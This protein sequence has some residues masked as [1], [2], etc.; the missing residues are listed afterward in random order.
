M[1]LTI[2]TLVTT[3]RSDGQ[4]R[5]VVQSVGHP[6]FTATDPL[7]KVALQRLAN[8]TRK[9]LQAQVNKGFA[10]AIAGWLFDSQATVQ[11]FKDQLSLRDR[12]V[13][14]KTIL[15]TNKTPG[16]FVVTAPLLN[17][18]R[19][20]RNERSQFHAQAVEMLTKW[21]EH[22]HKEEPDLDLSQF[23][24]TGDVWL[25]PLDILLT[26]S[27][28]KKKKKTGMM[29][30][31]LGQANPGG[32]EA[33]QRVGRCLDSFR[34]D[35]CKLFGRDSEALRLNQL[36]QSRRNQ[37]VLLVGPASVGKTAILEEVVRQRTQLRPN[38]L[39]HLEQ[40]WLIT[41][42]RVISGMSY[43]GQWEER[44]LSI[45][46][47]AY[48]KNH[49]L[50]FDD[51]IGLYTAGI[52]R[53]SQ[54]CLADVLKAFMAEHPIRIVFETTHEGLSIL[55]RRD[56]SL[57]DPMSPMVIEP[58]SET[59]TIRSLIEVVSQIES[60]TKAFFHPGL[61]PRMVEYSSILAPQQSMPGKVISLARG[62]AQQATV[63][64]GLM[65]L[66]SQAVNSDPD[67]LDDTPKSKSLSGNELDHFIEER[68]GL[69]LALRNGTKSI[70]DLRQELERMIVGQQDAVDVLSRYAQRSLQGL[71]P[72]DKPLGVFLFMG[73]TGV[74]KTE[75]A[76][77][78][79]R[80]LFLDDTRIV[81]I[82]MNEITSASAAEGLIGTLDQPDGRLSAA[83]RRQPNCVLLL[84]EIEKAHPD[85]LD[86]LLQVMGEGRLSDA[87]GRSVDFRNAF[88]IMTSNLGSVE[89]NQSLG[90]ETQDPASRSQQQASVYHRAAKRYFRP[91][92]LNRLDEIVVFGRL[93]R[94][95]MNH[96]VD[97]HLGS[98]KSRDGLSRRRI[99]LQVDQD[100]IEWIIDRGYDASLGARA[101]KRAIER[102]VA[103]PLA[104]RL[105][106]VRID[107]P[108]WTQLRV[109]NQSIQ[110]DT[111]ELSLLP[112]GKQIVEPML[113]ES[114]AQGKIQLEKIRADL[115]AR[116]PS[117][118]EPSKPLSQVTY[119]A[120]HGAWTE[121]NDLWKETKERLEADKEYSIAPISTI[122]SK[123][124]KV[125]A[126]SKS[127]MGPN[128]RLRD[129]QI[130]ELE[131]KEAI[132]GT[133]ADGN[134]STEATPARRL[135][136]SIAMAKMMLDCI[137][138][139]SRWLL[140]CRFLNPPGVHTRL[141]F[142]R[143][144]RG[145]ILLSLSMFPEQL[146]NW[147]SKLLNDFQYSVSSQEVF[148]YLIVDG[149]GV[150]GLVECLLG[151][152]QVAND[153]GME[154]LIVIE[155][156]PIDESIT[157]DN[158][159]ACQE[160][161]EGFVDSTNGRPSNGVCGRDGWT[162]IRGQLDNQLT[163]FRS[164]GSVALTYNKTWPGWLLDQLLVDN[165]V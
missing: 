136:R 92:F 38:K 78:L 57:V 118:P 141:N 10:N 73:P 165:S 126:H 164:G 44:W 21:C 20:Q 51:P 40:V 67:N 114:L 143:R 87:R 116:S 152:Y 48:R 76:K 25:E 115:L 88:I 65:V 32:A 13:A 66:S 79:T 62:L 124:T 15:I 145:H 157:I 26:A 7:L 24:I 120:V 135:M 58:M 140:R 46:K 72:N 128:A 109:V 5:F 84:D 36:L 100:A 9:H 86:Y 39:R 106:A 4:N 144:S 83:I 156:M 80:L 70:E 41:P 148:Q 69:K 18:F 130:S 131:M 111:Q 151:T 101:I 146:T 35:R 134:R 33:L 54:M 149:A 162:V 6:R 74:G 112:S 97:Q 75:S 42:G 103:Q 14:L 37:G 121:A 77:A 153:F 55:R 90:Y 150:S 159:K 142:D 31:L 125:L 2:A 50:Y 59:A 64:N 93:D 23:S 154:R 53:D 82:D 30:A 47:E 94:S 89:S 105:A 12:T 155:A 68:T 85:A 98:L 63:E 49:T 29:G 16:G 102:E 99:F 19:Y 61:L 28:T 158:V 11:V 3:Q 132:Q 107:S 1:Q 95:H 22:L 71:Q 160:I 137:D 27:E 45:L 56:R 161:L 117:N 34:T 17:D 123:P 147:I 91:E 60:E 110:C 133:G 129:E 138:A 119:Y 127:S 43:L 96:I 139:P 108:V 163:D 113:E 81:R 8:A 52:T 122:K 104:D